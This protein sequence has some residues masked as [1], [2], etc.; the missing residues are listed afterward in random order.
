MAQVP[1]VAV[2]DVGSDVTLFPEIIECEGYFE[3]IRIVKDDLERSSF[4]SGNAQRNVHEASFQDYGA[5]LASLE[6]IGEVS[7]FV[8][9]YMER[10][11]QLINKTNQFNLTTLR[12]TAA[13]VETFASSQNHITLYGRLHDKFGDNGLVSVVIG[14]IHGDTLEIDLWLMSCRVLKR[15]MEYAMFDSLV[16]ECLSRGVRKIVGFYIPTKKNGMVA[17]HYKSL[18]FSE[19][20]G[21]PRERVVWDYEIPEPFTARTKYID[22]TSGK[23]AVAAKD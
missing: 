9:V 13:E 8:P 4:Y 15:E 16:E 5:F 17:Q 22:R 21:S 18:G 7:P 23:Q 11:T 3:P 19:R 14:S 10:I 6:M 2:P 1:E 12:L 20:E